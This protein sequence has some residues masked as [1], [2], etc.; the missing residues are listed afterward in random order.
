MSQKSNFLKTLGPGILFASTCIGVSHLVQSTRAGANYGFALLGLVILANLFKYPFFEYSSRYAA[1]TGNSI[2]VGYREQGKW[3][4]ILFFVLSLGT[5]FTVTAAVTF[6]T[7]GL[8]GNLF[9]LDLDAKT[10]SAITLAICMIILWLGKFNALDNMLKVVAT[11]LVLSTLTAFAFALFNGPVPRID[12]FVP[13]PLSSKASIMFI[14]A[15]MG[16]MPTAVDISVWSGIWTVEK[17]RSTGFRPSLKE[18]LLDFNIGY[19]MTAVL[20]VCFLTLGAYVVYGTGSTLSDNSVTFAE[21]LIG[22]YTASIGDWMYWIIAIA[23]FSTMFSTTITVLDG[24]SRSVGETIN[25]LF[26]EGDHK[27]NYNIIMLITAVVALLVIY[28]LSGSL[29]NLVDLATTISFIIAPIIAYMNMKA[30]RNKNVGEENA[31]PKWLHYLAIAGMVFLSTFT[32]IYFY[33]FFL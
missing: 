16:W 29:K 1:A 3:T 6:V 8:M 11:A 23:A 9:G 13:E 7:G 18:T 15:L 17:T 10:L 31:P 33:Y 25:L 21:Q 4:L 2:L 5:M 26:F 27:K 22:L 20:A 12:T 30:I 28:L 24:Y 14:I 19:I 32:L